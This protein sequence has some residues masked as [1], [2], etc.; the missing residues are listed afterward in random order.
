[1]PESMPAETEVVSIAWCYSYLTTT[2]SSRNYFGCYPCIA[3]GVYG[4]ASSQD[5]RRAL[6]I[7]AACV[8]VV[9]Q[10]P[11]FSISVLGHLHELV[12]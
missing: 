12:E 10:H 8:V 3:A 11:R 9:V 2:P 4:C 1:M 7:Y 6:G 5:Q